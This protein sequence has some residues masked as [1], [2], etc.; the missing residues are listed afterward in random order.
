MSFD[1]V[2]LAVTTAMH[3]LAFREAFPRLTSA[4]FDAMRRA[5]DRLASALRAGDVAAALRADEEFHA[6]AVTMSG[7]GALRT[8]LEQF[9]P[10]LH[11]AGHHRHSSA[12]GHASVAQHSRIIEL[13]RAGEV[14]A[15]VAVIRAHWRSLAPLLAG[16]PHTR[17]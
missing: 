3:E 17:P 6:I 16:A 10:P 8:V 4:E 13:G 7:N 5:N 11:R 9:S 2:A 14:D 12:E 15:A 1:R